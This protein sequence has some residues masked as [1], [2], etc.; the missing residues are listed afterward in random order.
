MRLVALFASLLLLGTAHANDATQR[1]GFVSRACA[2]ANPI[3]DS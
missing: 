1:A 3:V 2:Q